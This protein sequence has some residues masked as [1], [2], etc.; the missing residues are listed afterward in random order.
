MTV[1]AGNSK[2]QKEEMKREKVIKQVAKGK[3]QTRKET[4]FGSLVSK[5][6]VN[7]LRTVSEYVIKD[8]LIPSAK[9]TLGEMLNNGIDM[10]LYGEVRAKRRSSSSSRVSYA[11]YYDRDDRRDRYDRRD[12][13]IGRGR[14]SSHDVLLETRVE[15]E[16]VLN[17]LD[18]LIDQY[19]VVSVA[20]LYDLVGFTSTNYTDNKFGWTDLRHAEVRRDRDGYLLRMPK[21]APIK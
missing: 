18:D 21:A 6:I 19:G 14:T 15:A 4:K 8:I 7:D 1:Y 12:S 5:F 13:N 17:T 10:M 3:V 2:K 16:E 9:R 11:S 20:D